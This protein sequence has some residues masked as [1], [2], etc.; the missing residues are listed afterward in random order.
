MSAI[1]TEKEVLAGWA[2][3]FARLLSFDEYNDDNDNEREHS[4]S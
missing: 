3:K 1:T 4:Y 2:V